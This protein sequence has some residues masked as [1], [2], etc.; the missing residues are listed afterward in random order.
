MLREVITSTLPAA[1]EGVVA[2]MCTRHGWEPEEV[3]SEVAEIVNDRY[4]QAR[5]HSFIP[6]LVEKELR[7]RRGE[8]A[9]RSP[10]S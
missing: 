1:L 9:Q 6:I 3:R 5:I 2:R 8:Q 4:A 10:P 7:E